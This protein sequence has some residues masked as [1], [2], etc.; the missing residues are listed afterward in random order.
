ML[1]DA[2]IEDGGSGASLAWNPEFLREGFAVQDTLTPDRLVYGVPSGAAG[3]HATALLN[4]VYAVAIAADTPLVVTDYATAELVKVSANAFLATKNPA[5]SDVMY[6]EE[7]IGPD[8]VN[9]VPDGTLV[10]GRPAGWH[11]GI[12][13]RQ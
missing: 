8:T 7:L 6:V 9:T 12:Y 1:V 13:F 5:R 2:L 4:E 10:A 3:E 11:Q